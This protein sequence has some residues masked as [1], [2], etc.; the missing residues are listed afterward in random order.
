MPENADSIAQLETQLRLARDRLAAAQSGL[1]QS[2]D[3]LLD[4]YRNDIVRLERELRILTR[5]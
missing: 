2:S 3:L 5:G 4:R 1:F